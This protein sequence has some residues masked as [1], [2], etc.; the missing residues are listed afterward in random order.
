MLY[1]H[2]VVL[3]YANFHTRVPA[4][5]F[6][7]FNSARYSNDQYPADSTGETEINVHLDK[8]NLL[9]VQK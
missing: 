3:K 7:I 8:K 1:D 4:I 5:L 2:D 6:I 9:I